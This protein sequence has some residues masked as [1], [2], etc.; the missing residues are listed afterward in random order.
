MELPAY[1][2]RLLDA[3]EKSGRSARSVGTAAGAGVNFMQQLKTPRVP[4]VDKLLAVCDQLGV[5]V[6]YVL[7]GIELTA[8]AE[9]MLRIYSALPPAQQER[10]RDLMR[11]FLQAA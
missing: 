8:E 10:L 4:T 5:S 6:T 7:T 9:E 11:G 1:K 2:R 3:L